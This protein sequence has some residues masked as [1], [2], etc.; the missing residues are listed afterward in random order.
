VDVRT[1]GLVGVK[2][3]HGV[4]P[5]TSTMDASQSRIEKS[6][7]IDCIAVT[8]PPGKAVGA[9]AKLTPQGEPPLRNRRSRQER[10][11]A[12]EAEAHARSLQSLSAVRWEAAP[13]TRRTSAGASPRHARQPPPA[14]AL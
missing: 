13:P 10:L 3:G 2:E 8:L 9:E 12:P 11:Q 6:T 7:I 14:R 4:L 1:D 5:K